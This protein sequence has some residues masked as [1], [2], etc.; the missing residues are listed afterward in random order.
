MPAKNPP[1]PALSGDKVARQ[2]RKDQIFE[3]GLPPPNPHRVSPVIDTITWSPAQ[4]EVWMVAD[5]P[6]PSTTAER[7]QALI[8]NGTTSVWSLLRP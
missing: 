1:F 4:R 5:S 8:T 7:D 3:G 2:C 6:N